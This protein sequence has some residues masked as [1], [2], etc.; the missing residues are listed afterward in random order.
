MLPLQDDLEW[1]R[2]KVLLGGVDSSMSIS[3]EDTFK[4]AAHEAGH[5]IMELLRV[6]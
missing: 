4:I 3:E 6:G 5:A 1:A 2:A